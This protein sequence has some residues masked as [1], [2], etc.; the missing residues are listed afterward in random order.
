VEFADIS[1][2]TDKIVDV[3]DK[4]R[5]TDIIGDLADKTP[6]I[7]NDQIINDIINQKRS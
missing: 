7:S 6:S 3:S 1:G 4:S 5:V 2:C